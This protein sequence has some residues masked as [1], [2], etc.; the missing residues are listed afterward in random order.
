MPRASKLTDDSAQRIRISSAELVAGS[1]N[2]I[3]NLWLIRRQ[4]AKDVGC[5]RKT[6]A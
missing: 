3:N 2:L 4:L 6:C 5:K 1:E